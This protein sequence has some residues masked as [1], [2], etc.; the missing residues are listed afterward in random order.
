MRPETE[1]RDTSRTC[2]NGSITVNCNLAYKANDSAMNQ[3]S[4]WFD[5]SNKE[6]PTLA[7]QA[8]SNNFT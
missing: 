8:V 1:Q 4:K 6:N 5:H 2:Q 7:R 3:R